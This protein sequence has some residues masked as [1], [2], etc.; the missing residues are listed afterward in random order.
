M[1]NSLHGHHKDG[2]ES[3]MKYNYSFKKKNLPYIELLHSS[4]CI[5]NKVNFTK[6]PCGL[7]WVELIPLKLCYYCLT[8]LKS[9]IVKPL[10]PNFKECPSLL[11][12][13]I[14]IKMSLFSHLY[15][16][17][18][19]SLFHVHTSLIAAPILCSLSSPSL[20]TLSP[21]SL[22]SLASHIFVLPLLL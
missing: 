14:S 21:Y 17:S 9:Y 8:P 15:H 20:P 7:P 1:D 18:L 11:K 16:L 3:H 19:C 10:I 6:H 4:I 13:G 12:L 2:I 22:L 5:W